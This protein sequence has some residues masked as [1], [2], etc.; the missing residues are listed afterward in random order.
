MTELRGL[1]LSLSEFR[2]RGVAVVAV[3]PDSVERNLGVVERLGLDF[4]ILSDAG[5]ALTRAFGLE[6]PG[7]GPE[8]ATVPRPATFIVRN[9]AVGWRDLTDNWRVRPRPE[10]ILAALTRLGVSAR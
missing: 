9:G 2:E 8:G 1:Q 7:A 6:H 4:P 5:L 3:S 10:T